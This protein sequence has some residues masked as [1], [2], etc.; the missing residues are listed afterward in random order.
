MTR[1]VHPRFA[2]GPISD[3]RMYLLNPWVTGLDAGS[4]GEAFDPRSQA[5]LSL[6]NYAPVPPRRLLPRGS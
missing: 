3:D 6:N 2:G 1:P 5:T 4:L